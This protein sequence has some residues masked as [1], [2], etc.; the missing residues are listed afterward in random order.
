MRWL[1][2]GVAHGADEAIVYSAF[3]LMLLTW[4]IGASQL[5]CRVLKFLQTEWVRLTPYVF[6]VVLF[7]LFMSR[8]FVHE[9]M[10]EYPH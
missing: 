2:Y 4:P 5:H 6:I 1:F 9:F 7:L 3:H 10:L 8:P